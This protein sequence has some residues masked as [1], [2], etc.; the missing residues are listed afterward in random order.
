MPRVYTV[1][2]ARKDYPDD[3]ISKGD[4]YY[5][6]KFNYGSKVKSKTYPKRSQLTRSHLKVRLMI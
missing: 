4:T 1:N 6:W 3:G 5:Y 2:A